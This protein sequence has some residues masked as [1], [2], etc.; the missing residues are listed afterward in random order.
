MNKFIAFTI[1]SWTA[2][3]CFAKVSLPL[4][5]MKCSGPFLSNFFV[6]LTARPDLNSYIEELGR[7]ANTAYKFELASDVFTSKPTFNGGYGHSEEYVFLTITE[8]LGFSVSRFVMIPHGFVLMA[9]HA[10]EHLPD[11]KI[12]QSRQ[13]GNPKNPPDWICQY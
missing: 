11:L 12:L 2:V 10:A 4:D 13:I 9:Q 3:L 6:D 7:E 1:V 5:K 8:S